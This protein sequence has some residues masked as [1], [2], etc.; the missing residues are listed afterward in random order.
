MENLYEDLISTGNDFNGQTLT[1]P[2]QW[3]RR[4][5]HRPD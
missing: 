2:R 4:Q 3:T 1:Q 5:F